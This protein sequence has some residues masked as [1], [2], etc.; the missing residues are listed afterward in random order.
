MD[1]LQHFL[2]MCSHY[3]LFFKSVLKLGYRKGFIL[4]FMYADS[5]PQY[6]AKAPKALQRL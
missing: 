2:L 3:S 1:H 6:C 4:L 5:V